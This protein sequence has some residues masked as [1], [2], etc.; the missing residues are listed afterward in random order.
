VIETHDLTPYLS[1][2][3]DAEVTERGIRP[4]RLPRTLRE[5]YPEPQLLAME[6]QPSGVRLRLRTAASRVELDLHSTRLAFAG[7]SR[8]RG[9]VDLVVDGTPIASRELSGGDVYE[10]DLLTGSTTAHPGVAHTVSFDRLPPREK[11]IE[12]WLPH[13]EA[14]ELLA[15][16]TDGPVAA[17]AD[18]RPLWIHHG[19]SISHGSNAAGPTSMWPA[20]AA[21]AARVRLR[22]LGFG[23]SALLDPFIARTI[24][25][26]RADVISVKIGINIVNLDAMRL[27]AFVPALHGFLDTIRDGHPSTPLVVTTP[28]H[29]A[30]HESTPGPGSVD[31]ATLGTDHVRFIATGTS[32][33]TALGRLTL[34]VIRRATGEAVVRRKDP[35]LHLV[36][37]LDLYGPADAEQLPLPDGLH[38]DTAAHRL[39]G[40]RFAPRLSAALGG[41]RG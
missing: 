34:E 23:G 30:I 28:I 32:G 38:P 19:S 21:R 10:T 4:H 16:R 11:T 2:I 1:D 20:V 3:A 39:I 14:V 29:C 25:D 15:L 26:S 31:A 9:R 36:D 35:A 17:V 13:N 22:N 40:E 6:A 5:L 8:P 24:R 27:R 7:A 41:S 18:E 12:L 33:D 37:G